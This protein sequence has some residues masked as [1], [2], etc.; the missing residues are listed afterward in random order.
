M[1]ADG[2]TLPVIIETGSFRSELTVTNFSSSEKQV[3]FG[4]VADVVDTDDDTATFSL[5]LKAGEQRIL[6][7]LVS[8]LRRQEVDGIGPANRAFVGALVATPA[9][10]G[11]ERDL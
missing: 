6:P 5:D 9:E 4:F 7:D 2:Q 10:G 8:W 3:N 11:H 1:G